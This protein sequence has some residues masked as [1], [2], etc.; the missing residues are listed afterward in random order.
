MADLR[1]VRIGFINPLEPGND[2]I[3][4]D[5]FDL[6]DPVS[7]H[8]SITAQ[9]DVFKRRNVFKGM[10]EFVGLIILAPI[11][12]EEN[13]GIIDVIGAVVG[14]NQKYYKL[15]IHI[16][17]LHAALG[18]PCDVGNLDNSISSKAQQLLKAEKIIEH[19]PWFITKLPVDWSGTAIPA[20]GDIIKV[21][22]AKGPSGGKQ[23]EG[24]FV[25]V[26]SSGNAESIESFCNTAKYERF[27]NYNPNSINI[28]SNNVSPVPLTLLQ[29]QNIDACTLNPNETSILTGYGTTMIL[30]GSTPSVTPSVVSLSD[31]TEVQ[32]YFNIDNDVK[33]ESLDA[34][35]LKRITVMAKVF[36]CV[37]GK[38]VQIN[39]GLRTYAQQK[40]IYD[41]W[42]KAGGGPDT[43]TA[44]GYT[45]PADPDKP[46]WVTAI[47][48]STGKAIDCGQNTEGGAPQIIAALGDISQFGLIW[49]GTFSTPDAV[50][51]QM[52]KPI[53]LVAAK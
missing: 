49:G 4:F 43:P 2:D 27:A 11:P 25:G 39:S 3:S 47:G 9:E 7:A 51:I 36:Y 12:I 13:S 45:T 22:F 32:N 1:K 34:E 37:T 53:S 44:A 26:I 23:V 50:H 18:N 29:Q 6:Q 8:R 21:K 24:E 28:G 14:N 20:F 40:S 42:K 31:T 41:K 46:G 52:A 15:K 38:K 16:P 48:H 10:T 17:E 5:P 19:H 30:T 33:L 35:F